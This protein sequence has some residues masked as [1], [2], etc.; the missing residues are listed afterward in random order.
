MKIQKDKKYLIQ[1][2]VHKKITADLQAFLGSQDTGWNDAKR[3]LEIQGQVMVYLRMMAGVYN[4]TDP[5]LVTLE[6]VGGDIIMR[7]HT[8]L[9]FC[10]M[11]GYNPDHKQVVDNELYTFWEFPAGSIRLEKSTGNIAFIER[12]TLKYFDS[13]SMIQ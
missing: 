10:L 3:M 12:V 4:C 13:Q 7:S 11:E 9:T 5:I 1:E 2:Q 6:Q 8:L